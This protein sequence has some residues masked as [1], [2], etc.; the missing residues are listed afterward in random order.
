MASVTALEVRMMQGETR[1]ALAQFTSTLGQLGSALREIDRAA[2]VQRVERPK[3]V[4]EDLSHEGMFYTVR[5]TARPSRRR[6]RESL[7]RPVAALVDGA[8]E[9]LAE[10]ELPPFYSE[11]TVSRLLKVAEPK[12]GI[13]EVS[14]ATVNGSVGERVGLSDA[15]IEHARS[16]VREAEVSIGSITGTLDVISTRAKHGVRV[17][18]F[19]P[20]NRRAVTG[21]ASGVLSDNLRN[22][23]GH[24]VTVRGRITRNARGQA[25][26]IAISDLELMPDDDSG[27]PSTADLL[28]ADPEWTGGLSVDEF[29]NRARRRA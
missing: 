12:D 25:I 20:V 21:T 23:W 6:D 7:L 2:V 11:A 17:S 15:L 19:D 27:R 18:V 13:R 28:G 22:Y 16:A 24:R 9:L 8:R 5:L 29:M 4:V 1:P 10:P 3:W 26:R 14:L